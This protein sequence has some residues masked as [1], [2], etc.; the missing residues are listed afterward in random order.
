MDDLTQNTY[1]YNTM[2][3]SSSVPKFGSLQGGVFESYINSCNDLSRDN[4]ITFY[5]D[6]AYVAYPSWNSFDEVDA[7]GANL[8]TFQREWGGACLAD[9]AV[10]TSS[11][12]STVTWSWQ[13]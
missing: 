5:N 1:T 7:Y 9:A 3:I 8:L 12:D 13:N 11:D 2:T 4:W 10:N 6:G